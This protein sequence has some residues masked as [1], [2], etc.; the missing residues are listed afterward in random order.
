M[1]YKTALLLHNMKRA[2][3]AVSPVRH[4]S[5]STRTRPP[6]ATATSLTAVARIPGI[7]RRVCPQNRLL[8]KKIKKDNII[9]GDTER[10]SW[11][12]HRAWK[13]PEAVRR[14]ITFSGWVCFRD[15]SAICL[16]L[17]HPMRRS[18]VAYGGISNRARGCH[19]GLLIA[20]NVAKSKSLLTM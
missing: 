11:G 5:T 3:V 15:A 17:F 16:S 9:T 19:C 7:L 18:R 4:I 13:F 14:V 2:S 12:D 6:S 10:G 1:S 20:A 8:E